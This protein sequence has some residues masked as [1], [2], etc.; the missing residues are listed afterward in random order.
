MFARIRCLPLNPQYASGF[1]PKVSQRDVAGQVGGPQP[2]GTP[3]ALC[4]VSGDAVFVG[5][6]VAR[7]FRLQSCITGMCSYIPPSHCQQTSQ[8]AFPTAPLP[9]IFLAPRPASRGCCSELGIPLPP[10]HIQF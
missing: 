5:I 9:S 4:G 10:T 7:V 1:E 2:E 6:A 3:A 8:H